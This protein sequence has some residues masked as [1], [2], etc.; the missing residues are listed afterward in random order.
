MNKPYL[1]LVLALGLFL[2]AGC[3][4]GFDHLQFAQNELF[5]CI[6]PMSG[7]GSVEFVKYPTPAGGET[8]ARV[9]IYYQGLLK[10]DSMTVEIM[11]RSDLVK[12][13]VLDD[14]SVI[15]NVLGCKY[16]IGWQPI[17]Q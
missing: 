1:P 7:F 14:T 15:P 6:H 2:A 4:P 8:T 3:A 13:Q 16:L 5:P 11:T 9:K 17:P 10:N 12:A